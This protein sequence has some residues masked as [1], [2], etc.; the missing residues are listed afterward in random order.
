MENY[1]EESSE[2]S[3]VP[4]DFDEEDIDRVWDDES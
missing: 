3:D 4:L 2:L 1:D